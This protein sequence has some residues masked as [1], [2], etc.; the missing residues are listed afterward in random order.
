MSTNKLTVLV[1]SFFL[2]SSTDSSIKSTSEANFF[3]LQNE[4][5][6]DTLLAKFNNLSANNSVSDRIITRVTIHKDSVHKLTMKN[7]NKSSLALHQQ[8]QPQQ[9]DNHQ[10][11]K[12]ATMNGRRTN[13]A[14]ISKDTFW[15]KS[16][17]SIFGKSSASKLCVRRGGTI[18]QFDNDKKNGMAG[19]GGG[20]LSNGQSASSG[21][22]DG[23]TLGISIV[24][25]SD[26]NVYVKDLVRN[27]PGARAGIQIGDQV[28]L[29]AYFILLR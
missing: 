7:D 28:S 24:Q 18:N 3:S 1:S 22:D 23:L 14:T 17:E 27:G 13:P 15:S 5:V 26:N 19:G 6:S 29:E 16:Q 4:T 2:L 8:Q 20:H 11:I 21:A 12:Y 10:Q 9:S 25:G